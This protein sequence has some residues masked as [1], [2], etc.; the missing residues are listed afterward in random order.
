MKPKIIITTSNAY[1][2][3]LP[4]SCYLFN[5][6]WSDKQSVE[7]VGYEKPQYGLP[8]N[9][10][11]YS[12]GQQSSNKKD[13]SND[14]RKYFE[15]Q[16]DWI[17]WSMEDTFL[18]DFVNQEALNLLIDETNEPNVGRINLSGEC[19]SQ[20]H[21]YCYNVGDGGKYI[22][23]ENEQDAEYR[24]ST[25]ISIWNKKFLLQYLTND[26]SPWEFETQSCKNDGWKIVGMN[27]QQCPI[28]H[29]EGVRRFDIYKYNFHGMDIETIKELQAI[30]VKNNIKWNL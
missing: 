24:L 21:R 16:S 5:K 8:D 25:Q 1:L 13:F 28:K 18:R 14:L 22:I 4:L 3:I 6:F 30:I 11:F 10:T 9:F 17:I 7:I 19:V 12:L 20:K 29:N 2:H 15:Q 27:K 26:L 23:Y